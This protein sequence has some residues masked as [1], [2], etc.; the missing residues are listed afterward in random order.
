MIKW[1]YS[2][3]LKFIL[4]SFADFVVRL[5]KPRANRNNLKKV[6]AAEKAI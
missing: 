1:L 6:L 5:T 2:Q 3:D 4:V